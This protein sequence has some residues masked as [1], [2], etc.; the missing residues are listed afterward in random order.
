MFFPLPY[1]SFLFPL[2]LMVAT[3]VVIIFF[4]C[5]RGK[6]SLLHP[7]PP[8]PPFLLPYIYISSFIVATF[9][10]VFFCMLHCFL[11]VFLEKILFITFECYILCIHTTFC[12]FLG[13]FISFCKGLNLVLCNTNN[14][15]IGFTTKKHCSCIV[16]S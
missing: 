3:S 13:C 1:F 9:M 14:I 11:N 2:S 4:S 16:R 5:Y 15:V 7:S 6:P 12:Y 8:P 10:V